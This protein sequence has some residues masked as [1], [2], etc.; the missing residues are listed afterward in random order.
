MKLALPLLLV[1]AQ[2]AQAEEFIFRCF[3]DWVCDPNRTCQDAGEDIRFRV[4]PETNAVARIGGN[5]LSSFTLLIGDRAV[6]VLEQTISGGTTTTTIMTE[7]GFA[8]HSENAITGQLLTPM[9]Y[10]GTCT[11]S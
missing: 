5:D 10:L 11:P 3:F 4:N 2:P 8:V 6:T 1:L 7:D 9:Q